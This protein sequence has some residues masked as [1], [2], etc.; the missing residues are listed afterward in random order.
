MHFRTLVGCLAMAGAAIACT[1]CGKKIA[2][3]NKLITVIN[4]EGGKL[5]DRPPD[6]AAGLNQMA[7][8]LDGAAKKVAAV[9][10]TV[11]ELQKH[12]D[13]YAQLLKDVAS[14]SRDAA[15]ASESKDLGK[16]TV[17]MKSLSDS[18]QRS[19]KLTDDING[20]C[21]GTK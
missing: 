2:E 15:A 3:C 17:A 9:E 19:S 18:A 7:D 13:D 6:D 20:F 16:I 1:G 12:R 10:V 14:A 8:D 21:H 11:P 5:S 4:A